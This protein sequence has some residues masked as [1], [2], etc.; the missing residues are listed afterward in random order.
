[1]R[2]AQGGDP[3]ADRSGL[4]P[5]HGSCRS[6][7]NPVAAPTRLGLSSGARVGHQSRAV[8]TPLETQPSDPQMD[9]RAL[10]GTHRTLIE[11]T[12]QMLDVRS[13]MIMDSK[14]N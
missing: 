14:T 5:S 4:R 3:R 13:R 2:R 9:W 11:N 12:L 7:I 8:S 6:A 1:M 10:A